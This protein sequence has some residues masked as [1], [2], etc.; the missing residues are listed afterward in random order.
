M[1]VLVRDGMIVLEGRCQAEDAETLLLAL[2]EQPGATVDVSGV[3]RVH[4]AVVQILFTFR[5]QLQGS[6]DVPFLARNIFSSLISEGDS[7]PEFS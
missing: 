2:Q 4:L 1:T 5:P 7:T 6:P 3:K